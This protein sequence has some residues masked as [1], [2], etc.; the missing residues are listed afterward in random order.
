MIAAALL[1]PLATTGDAEVVDAIS[2]SIALL[3]WLLVEGVSLIVLGVTA[4]LGGIPLIGGA[5]S[6]FVGWSWGD[7]SSLW[8]HAAPL[9]P[10]VTA[11]SVNHATEQG[12]NVA[13][14]AAGV[15]AV[16]HIKAV[17]IPH[18]QGAATA[19]AVAIEQPFVN[20][21]NGFISGVKGYIT[22]AD[23]QIGQLHQ[24]TDVTLPQRITAVQQQDA[25]GLAATQRWAASNLA[26]TAQS[27]QQRIDAAASGAATA[28]R[29][30]VVQ[31]DHDIGAAATA[32]QA[33]AIHAVQPQIA[34]VQAEVGAL[35]GY[36]STAIAPALARVETLGQ[37]LAQ[38][39]TTVE[40]CA[41]PICE[42]GSG[43]ALGSLGKVLQQLAP[44][45]EAGVLFA[46]IAEAAHNPRGAVGVVRDAVEPV[47]AE[48]TGAFRAATGVGV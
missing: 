28:L 47:V 3:A 37:A 11:V 10:A 22:W 29:S 39:I 32:A 17:D 6:R 19:S 31:I 1:V 9:P 4:L 40:E 21:V 30:A 15:Q 44:V 14:H 34:G 20:G 18:A 33:G 48:A 45:L 2:F 8:S 38:R 25:A 27:L 41:A 43:P 5:I 42:G 12:L 24:A 35:T 7:L 13:A 36:L 16:T 46:F 23:G 26:T